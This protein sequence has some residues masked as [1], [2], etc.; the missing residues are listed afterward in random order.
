MSGTVKQQVA[1]LTRTALDLVSQAGR[2]WVQFGLIVADV[3][4]LISEHGEKSGYKSIRVYLET[5]YAEHCG[6]VYGSSP[7]YRALQAGRVARVVGNVGDT[8]V[9][10]LVPLHKLIDDPAALKAAW[11]SASTAA[12]RGKYPNRALILAAM[13]DVSGKAG[14]SAGS[15]KASNGA[16]AK[17]AKAGTTRT[18]AAPTREVD[19]SPRTAPD[20]SSTST[21]AAVT[22][23]TRMLGQMTTT[24]GEASVSP[25]LV[26]AE[27]VAKACDDIGSGNVLAALAIIAKDRGDTA[28]KASPRK[29]RTNRKPRTAAAKS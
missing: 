7:A 6:P 8:S 20:V 14:P 24:Y 1:T 18:A 21:K 13:G 29:S 25:A 3:D 10:S 4:S 27:Y 26:V 23:L 22:R 2:L 5:H 12:G 17:A 19:T 15:A 11:K 9:D 28:A 16:K